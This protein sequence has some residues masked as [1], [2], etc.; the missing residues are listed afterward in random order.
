MPF[1]ITV[2]GDVFQQ[3]LDECIG[4]I[5]NIH[6]IADDIIVGYKEDQADHDEAITKLQQCANKCNLKFNYDK[7]QYKQ[8]EVTFFG[9]TYTTTGRKPGAVEAIM[10]IKQPDNKKELQSFLGL[11]QY[12]TKFM[13]EL[14]SLS[15]PLRFLTRKNALFNWVQEHTSFRQ[16]QKGI[17]RQPRTHACQ[18]E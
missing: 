2:A 18:P 15:E 12:L 5:E 16:H 13:P 14:A 10:T 17:D 4:D 8:K 1:G 7:I 3:K 11:C 6:C 9:E